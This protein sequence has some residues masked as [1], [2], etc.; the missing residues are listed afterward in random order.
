MLYPLHAGRVGGVV[1]KML[2]T[3]SGLALTLL[4]TLAVWTFWFRRR[5]R[6]IGRAS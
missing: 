6:P 1:W 3:L 2:M 5:R 4:G